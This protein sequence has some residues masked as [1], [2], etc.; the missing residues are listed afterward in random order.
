MSG[1]FF[2]A[3]NLSRC[4]VFCHAAVAAFKKLYD[5]KK[6]IIPP[7]TMPTKFNKI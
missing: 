5:G 2:L 3:L 1:T 4:S 6:T 7:G